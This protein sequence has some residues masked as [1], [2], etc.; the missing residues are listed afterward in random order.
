MRVFA[1]FIVARH[2]NGWATTTRVRSDAVG[3]PGGKLDAGEDA[4]TAALR[5]ASEEGWFVTWC[6]ERPFHHAVVDGRLV[7]WFAGSVRGQLLNYKEKGRI[8]PIVSHRDDIIGFGN[9]SALQTFALYESLDAYSCPRCTLAAISGDY[10]PKARELRAIAE[11]Q[12]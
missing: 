10:S 4:R 9:E 6:D 3:F 11:S 7:V 5:E 2:R 8:A 1:A 12:L